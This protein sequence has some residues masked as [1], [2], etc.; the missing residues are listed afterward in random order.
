MN[1]PE[2]TAT[3]LAPLDTLYNLASWLVGEPAKADA[4][5][6]ET[7]RRALH[8]VPQ[9]LSGTKLRVQL[10]TIM[11]EV[12]R[13]AHGG[14]ADPP[15]PPPFTGEGGAR[16][17]VSPGRTDLYKRCLLHTLTKGDLESGLRRLPDDLRAALILVDME[18]CELAEVAEIF[19]WQEAQAQAALSQARQCLYVLL[20]ADIAASLRHPEAE[21]QP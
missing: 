17:N 10:L 15:Q 3:R 7:Y 8:T 13:Q 14:T 16:A 1:R 19:G 12:Y 4:L 5:V 9:Q 6:H 20:Q 18:G 21:D 2:F 11:W